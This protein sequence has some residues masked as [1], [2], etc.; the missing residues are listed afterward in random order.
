MVQNISTPHHHSLIREN[1]TTSYS[2]NHRYV[3]SSLTSFQDRLPRY[4]P[5]FSL[6]P[7]YSRLDPMSEMMAIKKQSH[8]KILQNEIIR[9]DGR[10]F[11]FYLANPADE[12]DDSQIWSERLIIE[13]IEKKFVKINNEHVVLERTKSKF[14]RRRK[15]KF[16]FGGSEWRWI[17]EG[18]RFIFQAVFRNLCNEKEI[19]SLG[20]LEKC[21]RSIVFRQGRLCTMYMVDELEMIMLM[22]ALLLTVDKEKIIKRKLSKW[23]RRLIHSRTDKNQHDENARTKLL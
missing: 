22:T 14:S 10:M 5:S 9:D 15:M 1:E 3:R 19:W 7:R 11:H 17:S 13:T 20:H 23:S 16:L 21:S 4:T 18:N 2:N 8:Y 6:P 12:Y